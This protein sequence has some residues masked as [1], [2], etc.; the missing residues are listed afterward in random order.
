MSGKYWETET[1]QTIKTGR[2][3]LK[4][5]KGAGRLQVAALYKD[6][7]TGEIKQGKTAVLDMEDLALHPQS[8]DLLQSFI[9]EAKEQVVS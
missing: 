8:L 4:Y 1:P 6:Q 9:D 5:F 2:N 3:F 7:T